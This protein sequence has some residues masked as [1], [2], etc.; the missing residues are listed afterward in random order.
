M[1]LKLIALT[2]IYLLL[3]KLLLI[4]FVA[5]CL[6]KFCY[7]EKNAQ[8]KNKTKKWLST[9]LTLKFFKRFFC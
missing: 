8:K 7:F 1:M 9:P 4:Q 3:K 5:F 6:K 2:F